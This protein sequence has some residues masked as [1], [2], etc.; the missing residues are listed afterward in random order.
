MSKFFLNNLLALFLIFS[1]SLNITFAQSSVL[2]CPDF[3]FDRDLKTGI[4]GN[5]VYVLQTIL[6]S[7][8]RTVVSASGLGAPGNETFQFGIKTREALK[9]FQALFIEYI[10]VADGKFN[11]KTRTVM[12][13]VCRGPYFTGDKSCGVFGD[14]KNCQNASST[15]LI[16]TTTNTFITSPL[17]V[18]LYGPTQVEN[19]N[20]SFRVLL[21]AN[22]PIKT[23]SLSG[24]IIYN[25]TV[26]DFRKI[27]PT[28]FTFAV[29]PNS[30][31]KRQITLQ[32]EADVISDLNN[33]TNEV[34]SNELNILIPVNASQTVS[35]VT[36]TTSSVASFPDLD[37]LLA[38][39]GLPSIS[40][41]L[42]SGYTSACPSGYTTTSNTTYNSGQITMSDGTICYSTSSSNNT[43]SGSSDSGS[44]GGGGGMNI[45]QLMQLLTT[46]IAAMKN[47]GGVGGPGGTCACPGPFMGHPMA[48]ITPLGGAVTPGAYDMTLNPGSGNWVGNVTPTGGICGMS[49]NPKTGCQSP[50]LTT[51]GMPFMGIINPSSGSQLMGRTYKW[52]N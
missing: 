27:S 44:G 10:Q 43:S 34:A 5:D 8:G 45:Q 50:N 16:A 17:E 23:P 47:G 9:R 4:K 46:L 35:T 13:A 51:M 24:L 22:K 1:F 31:A 48:N 42:L 38:Q 49:Y 19:L 28:S 3:T 25:A 52:V 41:G 11:T 6:N 21:V 14:S 33:K 15:S 20:D 26:Q 7:D 12:N 29:Y 36:S 2:S 32:V 39:A 37:A 40:S 30:D 18:K